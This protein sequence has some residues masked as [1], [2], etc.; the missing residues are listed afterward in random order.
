MTVVSEYLQRL[1]VQELFLT[2]CRGVSPGELTVTD[3]TDRWKFQ[4]QSLPRQIP[5]D[6]D[7]QM[8]NKVEGDEIGEMIGQ[9]IETELNELQRTLLEKRLFGGATYEAMKVDLVEVA[10]LTVIILIVSQTRELLR[11]LDQVR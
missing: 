5:D 10:A 1:E 7:A 8:A 3:S 4:E 2:D 11:N 9:A 6:F